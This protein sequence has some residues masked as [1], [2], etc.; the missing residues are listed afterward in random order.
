MSPSRRSQERPQ[1]RKTVFNLWKV[2]LKDSG[3]M[4]RCSDLV[5]G[6]ADDADWEAL[7]FLCY[8]FSRFN[9]LS[10]FKASLSRRACSTSAT[11][12]STETRGSG[13]PTVTFLFFKIGVLGLERRSWF[14][15]P[16]VRPV[17]LRESG[18]VYFAVCRGCPFGVWRY[19]V[20]Q[21]NISKSPPAWR[22]RQ[23]VTA[24]E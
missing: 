2:F 16:P 22:P 14:Q 21:K 23:C 8:R 20:G 13:G 5:D 18:G 4:S 12:F 17:T 15:A 1:R 3:S 11:R 6:L 7:S 19:E 24:A 10:S 9:L